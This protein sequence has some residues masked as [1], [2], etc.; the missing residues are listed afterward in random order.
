MAVKVFEGYVGQREQ[1]LLLKEITILRSCRNKN[2]VQFFGVTFRDSDIWMVMEL[3]EG[4]LFRHL[5]RGHHCTWYFRCALPCALC[6]SATAVALGLQSRTS[7]PYIDAAQWVRDMQKCHVL[8]MPA[9]LAAIAYRAPGAGRKDGAHGQLMH[10]LVLY[11]LA[12]EP[13]RI[14]AGAGALPWTLHAAC[15]SCTA[16]ASSTWTSRAPTS[17]WAATGRPR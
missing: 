17:C 3:M 12:A 13:Q 16:G 2:I 11:L 8:W 7:D 4:N 15:T 6:P 14:T 9:W 5:A 1:E 10:R